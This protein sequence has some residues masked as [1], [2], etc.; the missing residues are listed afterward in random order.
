L[1]ADITTPPKSTTQKVK[2]AFKQRHPQNLSILV[3][4]KA[5][6]MP[7]AKLVANANLSPV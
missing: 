5:G 2:A 3:L 1:V 6:I 7:C 4:Y